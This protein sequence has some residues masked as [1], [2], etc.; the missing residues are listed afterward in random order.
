MCVDGAVAES[1]VDNP[2]MA[3]ERGGERPIPFRPDRSVVRELNA[4]RQDHDVA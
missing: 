2:R 3:K 4:T 1:F